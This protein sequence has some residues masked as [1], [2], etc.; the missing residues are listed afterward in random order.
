MM[1][2][3]VCRARPWRAGRF[4]WAVCW[5]AACAPKTVAS[6]CANGDCGPLVCDATKQRRPPSCDGG[7]CDG[8]RS[9]ES[10]CNACLQ[11][12]DALNLHG[13]PQ[14]ECACQ[15]CAYPLMACRESAALEG[16]AG[17]GDAGVGDAGVNDCNALLNCALAHTCADIDCYCGKGVS[18]AACL[19]NAAHG[20]PMGPCV[21]TILAIAHCEPGPNQGDCVLGQ[22]L[23]PN[24]A[25]GRAMAVSHCTAGDPSDPKH[26]G[27]CPYDAYPVQD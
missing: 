1:L 14:M 25:L 3:A 7:T 21:E 4:A 17:V 18:E 22:R 20:G 16:D 12:N 15:H 26:P 23:R 24:T 19:S 13:S 2:G 10:A 11:Q 5:L 6:D 8:F 27:A 9:D